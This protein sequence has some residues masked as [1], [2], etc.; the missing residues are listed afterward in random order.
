MDKFKKLSRT[1]ND[2][3]NKIYNSNWFIVLFSGLVFFSWLVECEY[4]AVVTAVLTLNYMFLTQKYLDKIALVAIV[5]PA[6]VDNNMRH[7]VNLVFIIIVGL[8]LLTVVAS[9]IY[10]FVKNK[11]QFDRKILKSKFLVVYLLAIV[12]VALGGIGYNGHTFMKAM[13][14]VGLHIALLGLYALVY[15][16]A[17]PQF[18]D[19]VIKSIIALACVI[20]A[21]MLVYFMRV[22]DV[23]AALTSK[24]MSL[25]WA[26]TNAVAVM[27]A[28]AIP[29]CFYLA[30]DKKTQW[31]YML[32]GTLFFCFIFLT[33]CRSMMLVGA[34][35][36]FVCLVLSFILLDR[37]QSLINIGVIGVVGILAV[38]LFKDQIF[39]QF[40]RMGLDGN[41]R[42]DEYAYYFSQFKENPVFGMGF[43]SDTVVQPDGMVRAHN[44]PLQIIVSMGIIGAILAVPYYFVRYK[45]F[46][47]K[48]S[49]FKVFA[50]IAYIAMA[51][52]GMVDCALI[53]SYKLIAVYMLMSAVELD[54]WQQ[55]KE[56]SAPGKESSK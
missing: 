8:L 9:A 52:Y 10:Y 21:E 27:L 33:N 15:K 1:V 17:G 50:F 46:V 19:I 38:V 41:G 25:G 20:V 45:S 55:Q 18:K 53:S 13:I 30:K 2:G 36:Y 35:V 40:I 23:S 44:T 14:V 31:P 6:F 3:L 51:G 4:I 26:I 11:G 22:D 39:N 56:I 54:T 28:F 47:E 34:G 42:L 37:R 29:F 5:V 24:S 32:L 43:F 48:K 49:L 12:A 16:G 7:R